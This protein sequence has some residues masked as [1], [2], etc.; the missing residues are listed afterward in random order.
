MPCRHPRRC[1]RPLEVPDRGS[2]PEKIPR[3]AWCIA[4]RIGGLLA[5]QDRAESDQFFLT[6]EFLAFMLG[7]TRQ[8]VSIAV[9]ELQ[10]AGLINYRCGHKKILD[11]EGLLLVSCECYAIVRREFE[12]LLGIGRA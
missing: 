11:R 3:S 6:H 5:T 10:E 12:R 7:V 8:S 1:W 4:D 9:G 2:A